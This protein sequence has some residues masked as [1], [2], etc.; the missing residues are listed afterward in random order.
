MAGEQGEVRTGSK[1]GFQ[2]RRLPV[3]SGRGQGQTYTR[4]LAGPDR[5]NS[6]N[7]VWSGVSSPAVLVPHWSPHSYRKT[8]PPR[9]TS[10]ETDTVAL[11]E[12]LEGTR[13]TRKGDTS[14]QVAPPTLKVVAGG[15][16]CAT[17][18][19]ITPTKT[20]S[21]NIYRRIKRRVG[22]TLKR[23][24][25]KGN[26]VP[27]RKQVAYKPLGNK[28]GLSGPKRVPRP[29]FKQHRSLGHR[30]HN[31]GCLYQQR[32]GDESGLP[33]CPTVENP[34]LVHEEIGN[35]QSTSHPRPAECY[36]RQTIQTWPDH[37]NRMVPSPGGV[38]SYMLPVAPAPSGPVCHQVQQQAATVC[39]IGSRPPGMGSGC[40]Q[41]V[42]GKS[43]PLCLST[44][45]HLGQSGGEVAG[46]PMQ[47]NH[48]DC[49]GVAQHALVLESSG[50]VQSDPIVSAQSSQSGDSAIQP[51]PAQEP[52]KPQRTC[53]APRATAIKE[54]GFSEAVAA[55]PDPSMRQSGPFLQSGA[56]VIRWTS[57][58]HL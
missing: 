57:G 50:H 53:L 52:V 54:Q 6:V 7:T 3:Q 5:Q 9:L 22:R 46:L 16:Q 21:A 8:N 18:S 1:T 15:K 4:T 47:Q 45:S 36:N 41:S 39:F 33:V 11:E 31:I 24:Y 27:S 34:V 2:L 43:G 30:Q 17:R 32:S 48:T 28:G 37:S 26:L 14:P 35:S 56:S 49:T 51:D 23:A 58:H 20:C 19:T 10:Y 25:C 42:L 40:T 13:I 55:Q 12:Q 38:P 44:S 29:H